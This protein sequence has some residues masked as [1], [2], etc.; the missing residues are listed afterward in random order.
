LYP[1]KAIDETAT[2]SLGINGFTAIV[3]ALKTETPIL[4]SGGIT[5]SDVAAILETGV[6]GIRV[7]TQITKDF[8]VMRTFNN[9]LSASS[10]DE[11]RHTFE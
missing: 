7:A 9:L 4:G 5:T 6:S 10:T 8:D 11:K 1:F 2:K 3:D